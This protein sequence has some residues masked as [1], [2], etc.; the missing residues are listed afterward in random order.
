MTERPDKVATG[1]A[2]RD[3]PADSASAAP[4]AGE[5]PG[6]ARRLPSGWY[7]LGVAA[8]VILWVLVFLGIAVAIGVGHHLTEFR[9]VGF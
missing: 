2:G 5:A 8:Q 9:Y 1:A 7:L 3:D 6:R 4:A